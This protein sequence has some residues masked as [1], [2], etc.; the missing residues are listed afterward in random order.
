[1]K[2]NKIMTSLCLTA[3]IMTGCGTNMQQS[4]D[5]VL[6]SFVT[7]TDELTSYYGEAEMKVY[8][9]DELIE[10]STIQEFVEKEKR[11]AITIDENSKNK[12]IALND[13]KMLMV[14][15][16]GANQAFQAA[17][18]ENEVIENSTQKEQF[19]QTLELVKDSHEKELIGEEKV[20][21]F[22][23]QHLKFIP[24]AKNSMLGEID[25]WVDM[26]NWSMIKTIVISGD[27]KTEMVYTKLD[28][29][30][31]FTEDTFSLDL[32]N[33]VKIEKYEE[34]P[35]VS[36]EEAEQALGR[37][38]LIMKEIEDYVVDKVVV[39]ELGGEIDRTEITI[40][41]KKGDYQAFSLSVF[42]QPEGKDMAIQESELKV[43]GQNAE[44]WEEIDSVSW[45][46]D[47]LRYTIVL[48]HPDLKLEEVI[49]M[50]DHMV[51]SA[52]LSDSE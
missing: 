15:D 30:P 5:E 12:S 23:T 21:G 34:P 25:V 11:K 28:Y 40:N 45:D 44:K 33:D 52:E 32:P 37:P 27:N 41:Y 36:V 16:E 43:R 14:Y 18:E 1:M 17:I 3:L 48:M 35:A 49:E 38:F 19:I 26:E 10:H 20:N 51:V 24:K 13:G 22:D 29:S 7:S 46:E 4:A 42:P 2:A 31:D 50:T 39:D 9:G 8:Q 47:G 6:S